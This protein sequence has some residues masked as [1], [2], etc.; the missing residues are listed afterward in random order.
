MNYQGSNSGTGLGAS[1]RCQGIPGQS[2]DVTSMRLRSGSACV[3]ECAWLCPFK[4]GAQ[5]N[6]IR[7][8][9]RLCEKAQWERELDAQRYTQ[10]RA[11]GAAH[12]TAAITRE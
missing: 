1:L 5:R 10:D 4:N 12:Q 8:R 2:G 11:S 3:S 6:T 9:L 7:A